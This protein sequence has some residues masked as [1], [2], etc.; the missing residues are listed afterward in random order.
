MS[1]FGIVGFD[2]IGLAFVGQRLMVS[3]IVD[4]RVISGELIGVIL[5]CLGTAVEHG[6]HNVCGPF[7]DHIPADNTMCPPIY[8]GDDVDDVFF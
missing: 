1:E 7:P 8:L 4:Q 3:W 2:R 5:Y 6:L